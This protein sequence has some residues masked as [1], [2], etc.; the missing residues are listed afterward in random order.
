V[1]QN[2]STNE[3]K[4]GQEGLNKTNKPLLNE[5]ISSESSDYAIDAANYYSYYWRN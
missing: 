5:N 1:R 4:G 2:K 3:Q